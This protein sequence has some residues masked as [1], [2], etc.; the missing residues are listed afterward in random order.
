VIQIYR[1][2]AVVKT[3]EHVRKCHRENHAQKKKKKK[4][5]E[6]VKYEDPMHEHSHF[7]SRRVAA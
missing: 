4:K 6:A 3:Q 1:R 2:I 7:V 5:K